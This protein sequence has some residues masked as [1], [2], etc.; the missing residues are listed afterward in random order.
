M[1]VF[2]EHKRRARQQIHN[3]LAEPALYLSAPD[4]VPVPVTVRLHLRF[5]TLGELLTVSAGFADRQ[6]LTPRIIFWNDQGVAPRNNGIVITRDLGAFRI[7]SDCAPDDVT[8]A[9]QVAQVS[10]TQLSRYGWD[11]SLPYLGFDAPAIEV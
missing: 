1:S 11:K 3:R 6:E 5:D 7:G 4:A 9:A 2:R 10:D 8:T